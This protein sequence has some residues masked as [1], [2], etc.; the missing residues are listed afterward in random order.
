[1]EAQLAVLEG[2]LETSNE[3]AA[4]DSGQHLKGKKEPVL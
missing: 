4:K 1:M 3:L 2:L